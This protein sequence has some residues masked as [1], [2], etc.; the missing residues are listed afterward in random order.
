MTPLDAEPKYSSKLNYLLFKIVKGSN[1]QIDNANT[2]LIPQTPN[3]EPV[4]VSVAE[5]SVSNPIAAEQV[6]VPSTACTVLRR[7]PPETEV[8]NVVVITIA[9]ALPA[10]KPSKK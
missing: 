5:V 2:E 8:A 6:A 10:R 4:S 3:R 7:T 9:A 1:S